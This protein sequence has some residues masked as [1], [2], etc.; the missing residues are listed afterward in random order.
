MAVKDTLAPKRTCLVGEERSECRDDRRKS[1]IHEFL[2]HVLDVFVSGGSLFIEQVPLFADNPATQGCL[3]QLMHSEA[4]THSLASFAPG[5]FAPRTVS[6]RPGT[7][8]AITQR[9]DQVTE[10]T[11]RTGDDHGFAF[12]C[13]GSLAVDPNDFTFVLTRGDAVVAA[14]PEQFSLGTKLLHES[15]SEEPS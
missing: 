15:L 2:N 13:H 1:G 9:L 3:G 10:R 12:G 5:P 6:Q 8:F 4:F 14:V 7:T 11:A